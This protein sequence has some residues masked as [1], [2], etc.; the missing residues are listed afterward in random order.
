MKPWTPETVASA[1]GAALAAAASRVGGAGGPGRDDRLARRRPRRAVR[2]PARR[3]RRRR[4]LRRGGPAGRGVGGAHHP[5][6]RR[7][8]GG[9][10][11][12]RRCPVRRRPAQGAPEPGHRL[13]RG[14]GSAGD[15][16]HRLHRQDL[17]QGPAPRGAGAAQAHGG[18]T[19]ELQ[20][21]DRV[22]LE[23]L[24]G[25]RAPRSWCWRWACGARGR[26]PSWPRS[27]SPTWP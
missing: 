26:S 7:A 1:A 8:A 23:I 2:R 14:A 13:A 10:A 12:R 27:P 20:H 3:E 21:G 5:R 15:R 9:H 16:S 22:P 18:L 19:G 4:H 11:E 17:H 25:P 6:A 24:N